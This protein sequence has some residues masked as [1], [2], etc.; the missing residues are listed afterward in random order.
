LQQKGIERLNQ[1][2]PDELPPSD[3]IR[4]VMEG[5]KAERLIRGQPT[6]NIRQEGTTIHGHIDLSGFTNEELRRI[7]EFAER[8]LF[9]SGES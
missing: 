4:A 2:N 6:E 1:M 5:M 3:A 8:G 9:G 7:V